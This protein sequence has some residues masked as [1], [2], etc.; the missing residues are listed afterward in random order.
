MNKLKKNIY[1]Y[2]E[3]ILFLMSFFIFNLTMF[4][5][6]SVKVGLITLSIIIFIIALYVTFYKSKVKR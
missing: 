6:V 1:D 2:L 4:L 3:E 5:F